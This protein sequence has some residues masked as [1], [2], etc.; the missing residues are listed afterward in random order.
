MLSAGD[1]VLSSPSSDSPPMGLEPLEAAA[2]LSPVAAEGREPERESEEKGG[3]AQPLW[4][5]AR[6]LFR[7]CCSHSDCCEVGRLLGNVPG[8]TLMI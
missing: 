5:S 1:A 3:S 2:C 7:M 6:Q 4:S 8:V